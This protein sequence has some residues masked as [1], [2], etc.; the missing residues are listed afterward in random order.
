MNFTQGYL[1]HRTLTQNRHKWQGLK[2]GM[3]RVLT[4]TVRLQPWEPQLENL[5]ESPSVEVELRLAFLFRFAYFYFSSLVFQF[6]FFVFLF[7]MQINLYLYFICNDILNL[8]L[9]ICISTVIFVQHFKNCISF[10]QELGTCHKLRRK[11]RKNRRL[12]FTWHIIYCKI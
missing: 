2:S 8:D 1:S 5:G 7:Q 4:H 6:S 12:Y 10:I 9:C 11:L 3:G